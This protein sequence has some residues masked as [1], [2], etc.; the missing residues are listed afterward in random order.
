MNKIE[1][2]PGILVY[3]NVIKEYSNLVLDIEEGLTA[4]YISLNP[5]GLDSGINKNIRDTDAL[6]IPYLNEIDE[7]FENPSDAFNKSLANIFY[8]NLVPVE[9]DY[10]NYYGVFFKNHDEYQLLRYGK[11]QHFSNHIDDCTAFPR[12]IS[13]A[14][15]FNDDYKGGEIN[16]P[17]FNVSYKPKANE[18]I[19]FPSSFIYNHSVSEVTDGTRYAVVSWIN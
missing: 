2:A 14:Y 3:S 5:G 11:G 10:M 8:K 15:Y 17:R 12:R 16:F 9:N 19:V 7:N 6:S 18:M 1:L 4:A 13:S